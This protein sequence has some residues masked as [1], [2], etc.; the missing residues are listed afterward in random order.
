MK[1]LLLIL[2]VLISTSAWG[3]TT[4]KIVD[5]NFVERITAAAG[6]EYNSGILAVT[7]VATTVTNVSTKVQLLFCRNSTASAVTINVTDNQ[8]SPETYF[9]DVS[10]AA[11]SVVLLHASVIGLPLNGG[12][13]WSASSNSAIKCQ[14]V[15]V[16]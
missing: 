16:Q 12:V 6:K 11:N 7:T 3:Q 4:T 13:K 9:P 14:V 5:G 1:N 10:V 15:G 2:G 8:A